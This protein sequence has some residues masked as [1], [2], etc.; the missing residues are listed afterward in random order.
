MCLQETPGL[1]YVTY[2]HQ[3]GG[4]KNT[5]IKHHPFSKV[6]DVVLEGSSQIC[7]SAYETYKQG[8]DA[9]R[10]GWGRGMQL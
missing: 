3:Q 1:I 2:K 10:K 5:I 9:A 4:K 7:L 8:M 6:L